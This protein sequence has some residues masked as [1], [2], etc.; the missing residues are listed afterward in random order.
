[1]EKTSCR[2]FSHGEGALLRGVGLRLQKGGELGPADFYMVL[3]LKAARA[4]N[5]H[6]KRLTKIAGSFGTA[7]RQIAS[8]L[9]RSTKP[10]HRLEVLIDKW[11][12]SVP[13]GRAILRFLFPSAFT[14]YDWLVF[15]EGA[16]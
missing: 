16:C 7:V 10:K 13:T 3:I 8:E 2:K 12:V 9:H 6:K 15:K 4:K 11:L 5:Y 1:M 14:I